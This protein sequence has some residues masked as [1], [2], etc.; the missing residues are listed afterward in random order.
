MTLE[1]TYFG[2]NHG[3]THKPGCRKPEID[4]TWRTETDI[5]GEIEKKQTI[6]VVCLACGAA[7]VLESFMPHGP[8]DSA[9][10]YSQSRTTAERIGYGTPPRSMSGL[11]VHPG[12][13][14]SW[15]DEPGGYVLTLTKAR[16]MAPYEVAGVVS[17][18]RGPRGGNSWGAALGVYVYGESATS[19]HADGFKTMAAAVRHVADRLAAKE[20]AAAV[21][22]WAADAAAADR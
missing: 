2:W 3:I 15:D 10:G 17:R 14:N 4:F 1:A 11:Y 21:A 9:Y 12:P 6:R 19:E 8:G 16:P 22:T 20:Q 5:H 7:L 13:A 18:I